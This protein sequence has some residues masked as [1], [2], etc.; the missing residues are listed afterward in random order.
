MHV[1]MWPGRVGVGLSP[2]PS[3]C[4]DARGRI[5]RRG[6]PRYLCARGPKAK[7]RRRSPMARHDVVSSFFP[8]P[9][10]AP[11]CAPA[12]RT[13][14]PSSMQRWTHRS[15]NVHLGGT[16]RL[17]WPHKQ[18]QNRVCLVRLRFSLRQ[19]IR[20]VAIS[21]NSDTDCVPGCPFGLRLPQRLDTFFFPVFSNNKKC[22]LHRY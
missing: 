15:L 21:S 20:R 3:P 13:F 8:P 22:K 19:P 2:S 9:T 5:P 4:M 6:I 16:L 1:G 17:T 18:R 10:C 14:R 11:T 12:S 7:R